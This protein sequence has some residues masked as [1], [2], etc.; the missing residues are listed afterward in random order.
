MGKDDMEQDFSGIIKDELPRLELLA[1]ENLSQALEEFFGYEKQTRQGGDFTTCAIVARKIVK[2]CADLK[3]WSQLNE[4]LITI[5][6]RRSQSKTVIQEA[7]KEA[8]SFLDSIEDRNV[9][10]E[11]IKTLRAITEGKIFVELESAEL[12]KRLAAFY[13]QDG[14]IKEAASVLQEVQVETLSKMPQNEKVNYILEQVR[15]CLKSNDFIRALIL[16]RKINTATLISEEFQQ[17]KLRYHSLMIEYF[18]NEGEFLDIARS[19]QSLFNTPIVQEDPEQWT[20]YLKLLSIYAVLSPYS[21][22]QSDMTNRTFRLKKLQDLPLYHQLLKQFL[23]LELMSWPQVRSTYEA[24]F[25]LFPDFAGDKLWEVLHL[26]VIEHNLRV[27]ASY[28]KRITTERLCHLLDLSPDVA[29]QRLSDLVVNGSIYAKIDRP[30]G[31]IQFSKPKA[32]VEHLNDWKNNISDLLNLIEK[33]C[34]LIQRETMVHEAKVK[35][36]K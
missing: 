19:Y 12:T 21:N 5:S 7:V 10:I 20:K 33:T 17:E 32:P 30:G 31:I 11:L 1:K 23:T 29:E 34:H 15:L 13:E 26:R 4:A 27:I 3:E 25:K 14:N 24:E 18:H 6:K 9:V 35:G 36:K 8:M 22:E 16:S 2:C 28:Y